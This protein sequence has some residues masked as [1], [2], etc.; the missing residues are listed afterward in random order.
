MSQILSLMLRRQ[1]GERW[2][3]ELTLRAHYKGELLEW[4]FVGPF[5]ERCR[6]GVDSVWKELNQ[7]DPGLL[8]SFETFM[9]Q[10]ISELKQSDLE[11]STLQNHV[12][13]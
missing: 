11:K 12:K 9:S 5:I 7:R 6:T 1:R 13:R 4:S 2:Q 3:R 10:V 8:H